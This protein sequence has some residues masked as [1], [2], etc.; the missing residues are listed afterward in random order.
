MDTMKTQAPY[1][2]LYKATLKPP[3]I[4]LKGIK[5][6]PPIILTTAHRDFAPEAFDLD[7]VDYILKPVSLER[8]M[9]SANK[10]LEGITSGIRAVG[11]A[12]CQPGFYLSES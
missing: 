8:L 6:P 11:I 5:N 1:M 10:F 7:V 2:T 12:F 3:I 4:T 9:K